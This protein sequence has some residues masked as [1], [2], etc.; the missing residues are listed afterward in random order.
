[1]YCLGENEDKLSAFSVP[2]VDTTGAGDSF[3]AGFVHQLLQTGIQNL[4]DAEVVKK[5]IAYA[6]AAGA[7]TTLKPGAIASQP[8]DSE[9]E[10]FLKEH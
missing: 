7:L 9:V 5:I 8:T 2:V 10:S 6:S 1:A 4:K 3:V